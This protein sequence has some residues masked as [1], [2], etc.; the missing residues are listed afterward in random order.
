MSAPAT[1]NIL[2]RPILPF[3][4]ACINGLLPDLV[5]TFVSAPF[6]SNSRTI[7]R[8]SSSTEIINALRELQ[9]RQSIAQ[10]CSSSALFK[11]SRSDVFAALRTAAIRH[12]KEIMTSWIHAGKSGRSHF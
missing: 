11:A 5:T 8:L 2:H 10:G 1:S 12:Q 7:S 3:V 4:T 9:S 6:A